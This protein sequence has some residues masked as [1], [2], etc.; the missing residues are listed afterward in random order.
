MKKLAKYVWLLAGLLAFGACTKHDKTFDDVTPPDLNFDKATITGIVTDFQGNPLSNATVSSDEMTVNSDSDGVYQMEVPLG[1]DGLVTLTASYP[2]KN[3][4]KAQVS[5]DTSKSEGLYHIFQQNF[6]LPSASNMVIFEDMAELSTETLDFN[7]VAQVKNIVTINPDFLTGSESFKMS[8]TYDQNEVGEASS[9]SAETMFYALL[10]EETS[11]T[12]LPNIEYELGL[13][14]RDTTQEF[15]YVKQYDAVAKGWNDVPPSNI[16]LETD[17]LKIERAKVGTVYGLFGKVDI[18]L[19]STEKTPIPCYPSNVD[20]LYGA[21]PMTIPSV[22]FGYNV[23]VDINTA[24]V[25]T[26]IEGL[27][28]ERMVTDLGLLK[29]VVNYELPL[30]LILPIGT[31]ADIK[32]YQFS[33]QIA[34]TTSTL[35]NKI[36]IIPLIIVLVLC[37][38]P[39]STADV[40]VTPY[41]RKHTGGSN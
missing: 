16:V 25:H 40:E 4:K 24:Q 20:N 2:G 8:L 13:T 36:P 35:N 27:L 33:S 3:S 30:N 28:M 23:G 15:V 17:L 5:L 39:Y 38:L 21:N 1:G 9:K 31:G 26:Q 32:C 34:Y 18:D 22:K 29:T 19:L 11:G 41:D 12:G 14:L 6:R 7:S 10:V 37:L